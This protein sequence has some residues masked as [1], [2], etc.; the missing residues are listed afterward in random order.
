MASP[1][2]LVDAVDVL[3]DT[4][5]PTASL[6]GMSNDLMEEADTRVELVVVEEVRP[7]SRFRI[8]TVPEVVTKAQRVDVRRVRSAILSSAPEA[9][10][11]DVSF[12]QV[13]YRRVGLGI[14][15]GRGWE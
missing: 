15:V 14:G 6:L 4:T 8:L 13:L 12:E 7:V 9:A 3:P 1:S 5:T 11:L 10:S 2:S